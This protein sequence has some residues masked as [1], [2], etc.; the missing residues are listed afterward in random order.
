MRSLCGT[1]EE[2]IHLIRHG[3]MMSPMCVRGRVF[4]FVLS[5]LLGGKM[6][7]LSYIIYI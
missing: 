5:N 7:K 3:L 4:V 6:H 2:K 1:V